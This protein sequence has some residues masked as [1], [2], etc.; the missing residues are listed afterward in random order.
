MTRRALIL[1]VAISIAATG[2]EVASAANGR[3]IISRYTQTVPLNANGTLQ[4]DNPFG[5]VT[6]TGTTASNMIIIAERI[7]RGTNEEAAREGHKRSAITLGGDPARRTIRSIHP[8]SNPRYSV[9]VNYNIRVPQGVDVELTSSVAPRALIRNINGTVRVKN[10]SG[11]VELA[12]LTGPITVD[13]INGNIRVFYESTPRATAKLSTVNGGIQVTVP[14]GSSFAWKGETLKGEF[15]SNLPLRGEV[16]QANGAR[17]YEGTLRGRRGA[18]FETLSVTGPT[19]FVER[20]A[21]VRLA[22]S[23]SGG[24]AETPNFTVATSAP[25]SRDLKPL[26]ATMKV[27]QAPPTFALQR[28]VHHGDLDFST[29]G[30]VFV[31]NLHG[32]AKVATKA[33]HIIL[34]QVTGKCDLESEGGPINIGRVA[35]EL[36]A[37]TQAGDVTVSVA[38]RGGT[39]E[40]GG[41]NVLVDVVSGPMSITSGGGDVVVRRTAERLTASTRSGD[42]T[43]STDPLFQRVDGINL[44]TVGGNVVLFLNEGVRADIDAVITTTPESAHAVQSELAGLTITREQVGSRVRIRASGKFNGGG[45]KIDIRVD[46]GNIQ[47]RRIPSR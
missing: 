32:N 27:M 39:I 43:V 36:T 41:G 16:R 37:R 33:G 42:I 26:I 8:A 11:E 1:A 5:V 15:F 38:E 30:N 12:D 20:G 10:V 23:L 24:T 45:G 18:K 22:R 46:D 40:T 21:D 25:L 28:S 3:A 29:I 7:V 13:T 31:A 6:V 19:Y 14:S 34:G 2:A 9:Q 47:L 4:I 17:I 35:G 44:S